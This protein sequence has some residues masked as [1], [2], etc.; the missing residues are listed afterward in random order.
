MTNCFNSQTNNIDNQFSKEPTSSQT[1]VKLYIISI[2][3]KL[4]KE[5]IYYSEKL[6][7]NYKRLSLSFNKKVSKIYER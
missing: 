6:R 5:V 4:P 3:G 7:D 2:R 1:E